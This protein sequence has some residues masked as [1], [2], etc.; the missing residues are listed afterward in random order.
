MLHY[1]YGEQNMDPNL[2]QPL[3]LEQDAFEDM[4][5]EYE[6]QGLNR[7]RLEQGGPYDE[8]VEDFDE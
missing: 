4:A 2:N 7:I 5:N 1:P 6:A 8:P 3:D